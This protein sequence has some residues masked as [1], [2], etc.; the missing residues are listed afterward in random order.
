MC[1]YHIHMQIQRKLSGCMHT[2]HLAI[3][4]YGEGSSRGKGG[5]TLMFLPQLN[6][7]ARQYRRCNRH[8]FDPWVGKIPWRRKWQTTPV[9]LPGDSLGQRTLAGYSS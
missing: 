9:C 5:F 3:V 6:L 4:A 7:P 8:G 1:I 2:T